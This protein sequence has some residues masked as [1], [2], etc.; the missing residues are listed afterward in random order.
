MDAAWLILLK[1]ACLL[2]KK[3][4]FLLRRGFNLLYTSCD[5]NLLTNVAI[6]CNYSDIL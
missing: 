2:K 3:G 1:S 5:K 4:A 6:R